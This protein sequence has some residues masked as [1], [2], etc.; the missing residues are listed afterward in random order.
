MDLHSD[1]TAARADQPIVDVVADKLDLPELTELARIVGG[2]IKRSV[3]S[4][5][6][7][8]PSHA[9]VPSLATSSS[10]HASISCVN[11]AAPLPSA[12]IDGPIES[13]IVPGFFPNNPLGHR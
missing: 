4:C 13:V 5:C 9:G 7:M 6:G 12:D 8:V 3:L 10:I 11:C 1:R 2:G